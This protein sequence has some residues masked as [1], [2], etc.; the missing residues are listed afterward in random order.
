MGET[1]GEETMAGAMDRLHGM[2]DLFFSEPFSSPRP[3]LKALQQPE[4]AVLLI[5][6]IDKSD[7]AFEAFLLEILSDFQ[8]SVPELGVIKAITPPIVF[9]TSNNVRDLGAR[10][11]AAACTWTSPCP[12]RRWRSASWPAA[13]PASTSG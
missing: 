11:Y 1:L 7:E 2:G 12:I 9:L 4:G 6:E 13:C 3:L 8:V 10:C 5:D